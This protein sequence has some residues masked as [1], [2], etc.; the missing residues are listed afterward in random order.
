[1]KLLT[2]SLLLAAALPA[3]AADH[4]NVTVSPPEAEKVNLTDE[5]SLDWIHWGYV[6]LPGIKNRK[7]YSTLISDLKRVGKDAFQTYENNPTRYAW[8]DGTPVKEVKDTQSGIFIDGRGN[9]FEFSA[10]AATT[11]R[12]LKVFAGFWGNG[13]KPTFTAKLSAGSAPEFSYVCQQD[14]DGK[15]GHDNIYNVVFTITFKAAHPEATLNVRYVNEGGGNIELQCA[16]L[17]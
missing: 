13:S 1:M 5:G 7:T 9:G 15:K 10:P 8:R 2:L 3:F 6:Q 17:R 11:N 14:R 4:L 12:T 16:T